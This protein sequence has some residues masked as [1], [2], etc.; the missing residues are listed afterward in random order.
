MRGVD[1]VPAD[2]ACVG[3]R[4]ELRE[5][6]RQSTAVRQSVRGSAWGSSPSV[7]VLLAIA[8]PA[9]CPAPLALALLAVS[10]LRLLAH[11][12]SSGGDF[13]PEGHPAVRKV[14]AIMM[15]HGRYHIIT[16]VLF[17]ELSIPVITTAP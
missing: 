2:A 12:A 16:T 15:E 6:V 17:V 10:L 11:T 1:L 14:V 5:L 8:L 7:A 13:G 3:V 9:A 4:S